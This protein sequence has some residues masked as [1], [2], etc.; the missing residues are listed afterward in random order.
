MAGGWP[1]PAG[2]QTVRVWDMATSRTAPCYAGTPVGG[3]GELGLGQP[4]LASSSKDGS[5]R[6]WDADAGRQPPCL[7]TRATR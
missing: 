7:A 5:I 2:T 1:A 6:V 3:P 4:R